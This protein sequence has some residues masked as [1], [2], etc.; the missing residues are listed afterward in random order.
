MEALSEQTLSGLT[1]KEIKNLAKRC[2]IVMTVT[3]DITAD[4]FDYIEELET[5]QSTILQDMKIDL[6]DAQVGFFLNFNHC[7]QAIL[8]L[9]KEGIL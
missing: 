2:P 9:N 1:E 8:F 4:R 7:L 3:E 6:Q 5:D